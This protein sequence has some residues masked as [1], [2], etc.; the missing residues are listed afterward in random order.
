MEAWRDLTLLDQA[1]EGAECMYIAE[2]L[3]KE[4]KLGNAE[5]EF[6]IKSI[7]SNVQPGSSCL[8]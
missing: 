7:R 4:D 3:F 2:R 1:S 5:A 6:K 8:E